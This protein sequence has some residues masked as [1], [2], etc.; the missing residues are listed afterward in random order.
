MN[1][2][3][4]STLTVAS[5]FVDFIYQHK[6]LDPTKES[7][8]INRPKTFSCR[9]LARIM[10]IIHNQSCRYCDRMLR[11]PTTDKICNMNLIWGTTN[12]RK[13]LKPKLN[14]KIHTWWCPFRSLLKEK[15]TKTFFISA[16][17]HHYL[18]DV[19]TFSDDMQ[20]PEKSTKNLLGALFV[21]F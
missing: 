21:H 5:S 3:L 1:L 20:Y 4:P 8:L 18:L 14:H 11:L 16:L 12:S 17:H 10:R 13:W 2:I 15:I 9:L 6:S 7:N 19:T